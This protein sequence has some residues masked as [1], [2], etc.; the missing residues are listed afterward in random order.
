M[1]IFKIF[2]KPEPIKPFYR[3]KPIA[4]AAIILTIITT[5]V[6]GPIGIIYNSM[7]E[8]L[9]KKVDNQTLQ[10]MLKNQQV[11]IEQNK[12]EAKKQREEDA[13]KFES[14]QK[15]QQETLQ[16]IQKIQLKE[17]VPQAVKRVEQSALTPEVIKYYFSLPKDKQEDFRH[18]HPSYQALPVTK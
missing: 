16:I 4:T 8:D 15:S 7:S 9:E 2:A 13:K 12:E 11:L 14:L 17:V 10:L 1:S 6:L 18:L 5:F 3:E